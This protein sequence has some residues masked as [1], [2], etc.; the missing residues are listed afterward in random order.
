MKL[1]ENHYYRIKHESLLRSEILLYE[2]IYHGNTPNVSVFKTKTNHTKFYE[3]GTFEII[4][5]VEGFTL[6]KR[7][8]KTCPRCLGNKRYENFGHINQGLCFRCNG[9]GLI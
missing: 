1:K 5:E 7:K 4:A 6:K 3:K 8:P 9:T 2:G